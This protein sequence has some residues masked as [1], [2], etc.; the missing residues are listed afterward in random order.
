MEAKMRIQL[1][2]FLLLLTALVFSLSPANASQADGTWYVALSG[3]DSNPCNSPSGPCAT[4]NGAIVKA[5]SGDTILVVSGIYTGSGDQVVAVDKSIHLSG[6]WNNSFTTQDSFTVIDGENARGGM[7][8]DPS[9]TSVSVERFVFQNGYALSG[10]GIYSN[11][12]LTLEHCTIAHNKSQWYGGGVAVSDRTLVI[13]SSSVYGNRTS[14]YGGGISTSLLV[15]ENTTVSENT[16]GGVGGGL[17]IQGYNP[18]VSINNNT[19]S[20]NVGSAGGGVFVA[21]LGENVAVRNTIIAGNTAASS[22]DCGGNSFVSAGYNLIGDTTGCGYTPGT[23]DQTGVDPHLGKLIGPEDDSRY[24]PLLSSSPAINTGNPAGCMGS[25]GLLTTDQRGVTRVGR[26]DIGA[27]EYTTPGP[28]AYVYALSGT[29]QHALPGHPFSKRLEA[30]ILDS[31]GSPVNGVQVT[32]VAPASGASGTFADTDTPVTTVTTDESGVATAS[33]FTANELFGSYEVSATA[34]GLANTIE[35][36]LSNLAWYVALTGNDDNT[37]TSPD[38][39]CKTIDAAIAKALPGDTLYAATGIYTGSGNNVVSVDRDLTL[40]G[41]W[42][43]DFTAQD[44]YSTIDGEGLRSGLNV[45]PEVTAQVERL[46]IQNSP[47]GIDY[48]SVRC[49]GRLTFSNVKVRDNQMIGIFV[50]GATAYLTLNNSLISTNGG[51]GILIN[52]AP[53]IVLNN[54]TVEGN[55]DSGIR[56]FSGS[57]ITPQIILNNS[58]VS[59][60]SGPFA[61][62]IDLYGGGDAGVSNVFLNNTTISNN[63]GW[64]INNYY[65]SVV[66]RNSI[67]ARNTPHDCTGTITS[68]GYNLIGD[69]ASCVFT[70]QTGDLTGVDPVLGVLIGVPESPQYYPLLPGSPAIDA[71]NPAGCK[72]HNEELLGTDQR[73]AARVGVCDI[74]AYEYTHPGPA[75]ILYA[76]AGTPQRTIPGTSFSSLLQ[77][78]VLDALGSPAESTTVALTAPAI[79]P[80]GHFADSGTYTT[81]AQ[82]ASNAIASSAIFTANT[83]SGSY[84]VTATITGVSE[85][86]PFLLH[87]EIWY[88]SPT[89]DDSQDCLHIASACASV[90]AVLGKPEFI[91]GD[92]IYV[93]EGTYTSADEE[94]ILFDQSANVFGGWDS[95]FSTQ[96]GASTFDAQGHVRGIKVMQDVIVSMDHLVVRGASEHGI[97]SDG[98]LTLRNCMVT[99]NVVSGSGA[100]LTVSGNTTLTDCIIRGNKSNYNGG[101]I[102]NGGTLLIQHSTIDQNQAGSGGGILNGYKLVLIDSSVRDN[103]AGYGAGITNWYDVTS[104]NSTIGNNTAS[105]NGGGLYIEYS[106]YHPVTVDLYSTTIDGNQA[107]AGGGFYETGGTIITTTDTILAGNT[108][109]TGPDC[110]GS[111]ISNNF[112]LIGN[113]AGCSFTPAGNDLINLD[114][115]TG[116]LIGFPDSPRYVPLL[117]GSPAIDAG[118]PGGCKDNEGVILLSDQRGASRVGRCDIGA[119]EYTPAGTA[120]SLTTFSG[121]AQHTPPS[122]PFPE[123][124]EVAVMDGIGSPVEN[125]LVTFTAPTS[126]PSGTF[127]NTGTNTTTSL[128]IVDGIAVSAIFTANSLMGEYEV[129]AVASGVVTPA[130]FSLVNNFLYIAPGGD[131]TGDCLSPETPCATFPGVLQKSNPNDIIHAATGT[132]YGILQSPT[133]VVHL[134]SNLLISGGWDD[135]YTT[136]DGFSTVDGEGAH[137]G[138]QVDSGVTAAMIRFVIQGCYEWTAGGVFNEGNLALS[139]S[140]ITGNSVYDGGGSVYNTGSLTL[141]NIILHNNT[142]VYSGNGGIQNMGKL[143]VD[144]ATI[145]SNVGYGIYNKSGGTASIN[146]SIISDHLAGGINNAGTMT[147]IQSAVSNNGSG[148]VGGGILNGGSLLIEASSIQNNNAEVG[149]GIY[150]GGTLVI[151]ISTISGNQA[152]YLPN[153]FGGG[154]YNNESGIVYLNS[155]TISNNSADYGGGLYNRSGSSINTQNTI[156]AKNTAVLDG[157]DCWGAI[158]SVGYNLIGNTA[159]CTYSAGTGDLLNVD[160]RLFPLIR[161]PGYHPFLR[162]SPAIDTGTPAGCTDHLGNPLNTDQRGIARLGRCDI[163]A[164]EYDPA[165]DPVSYMNLPVLLTPC[166]QLYGDEFSNPASGWPMTDDGKIRYEYID[167]EYRILVRPAHW[168]A[169]ARPGFQIAN[170]SVAVDLHNLTGVKGSYGIAFGIAEDWSTFYTFEIYQDGKFGIYRYDPG[171]IV[172]L[173]AGSSPYIHTGKTTNHIKI[174]RYGASISA[175]ANNMLLASVTDVTYTGSRYLGLVVYSYEKKNVD[176]RFDNFSV[177][178]GSCGMENLALIGTSAWPDSLVPQTFNFNNI[179]K[180][181]PNPQR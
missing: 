109:S 134:Q 166:A 44:S 31:I 3:S 132:Y 17:Y 100:G 66:V 69:I 96:T 38:T 101:G 40:S 113:T 13:R 151:N 139:D 30:A 87:N 179:E 129:T 23:G 43:P 103:T 62:G 70:P 126:G 119:Y 92:P 174:V 28:A 8:V 54:S 65:G 12:D 130:L 34:N 153:G 2:R 138:V 45:S 142:F 50:G 48:P 99:D 98:T 152:H 67:I 39:P 60:N 111:L 46:I 90:K 104:V 35:Y 154:I 160:P 14:G 112:N 64:G 42:N 18:S 58:T 149:G 163:G 137:I 72:D 86:A 78:A 88:V 53:E 157:F 159:G 26:C 55:G 125:V 81:T 93:A 156:L 143:F 171:G 15:M 118:N 123:P 37:C 25:D 41:G 108:A 71:G 83:L 131:D 162:R 57:G 27:Y 94:V 177:Y 91:S 89:G 9:D 168:G 73:G 102:S 122:W 95:S 84:T 161:L 105:T 175:Y 107:L 135:T 75:A 167:G 173:A 155:G 146:H 10:G 136:Q 133:P 7:N 115:G 147:L 24:H 79:G 180:G 164:Y 170:F 19:F 165:Y 97:Y 178:S 121:K 172:T 47:A 59:G 51:T 80:S 36:S 76:F 181:D 77:V 49:A 32:F 169:L 127:A 148:L 22:P 124:L 56:S 110:S 82:S 1:A 21:C 16:S 140:S 33:E 120:T 117:P 116:R 145:S 61:G 20:S 74:G 141:T 176:I 114:A 11:S 6:G 68:Q 158:N 144:K 128:S 29:P 52:W 150:N 4:I 63:I 5:V 85:T 106:D